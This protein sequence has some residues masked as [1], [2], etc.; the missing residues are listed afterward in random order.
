LLVRLWDDAR[1]RETIADVEPTTNLIRDLQ[2]AQRDLGVLPRNKEELLWLLYLRQPAM[3][4]TW[5]VLRDRAARSPV[6]PRAMRHLPVLLN[7]DAQWLASTRQ[8][9]VA[10]LQSRL[11]SETHYDKGVTSHDTAGDHPQRLADWLDAVD[12]AD[13]VAMLLIR[14]ALDDRD[15]QRQLFAQAEADRLDT[16]T[17]YGG[18][19]LRGNDGYEA[20]AYEPLL[21]RLDT[22]YSSPPDLIIRCYTSLA[23]YHFHAQRHDNAAVAGP[24]AGDLKFAARLGLPCIVLT[25][26]DAATM[27][28][29]YYHSGG[30][31]VDLGVVRRR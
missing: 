14:A 28:V 10:T 16:D 11:R 19:L 9:L 8:K 4:E 7:A 6:K 31:R 25:Y 15:V 23:H 27:N 30:V 5:A 24:G 17:E 21:K 26:V 2:A 22:S 13:L 20:R 1:L 29:D 12:D 18:A 3:Q